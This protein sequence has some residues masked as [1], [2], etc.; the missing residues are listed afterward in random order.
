[1]R[2]MLVLTVCIGVVLAGLT[3]LA[4][5]KRVALV[6]GNDQYAGL[7]SL[8][9]AVNDARAVAAALEDIGFQ[10]FIGEDLTRRQ[11]NRKLADFE[12]AIA[13]G[14]QVFF[15][16]AGHGVS[17]GAENYL[18][19][20]DMPKPGTGEAGLVRDEA[21]AVSTLISRVQ[22]RG[23]ASTF[24]VLDACRDNPFAA[25]GVRSIG[26]SR[27][28]AKV[29]APNG[30]FVLFSAGIGQSALD[31]LSDN[32][33]DANSVFTRKLVPLLKR[34]GLTHVKLA[35]QVQRQV[36]TLAGTVQHNQQ[37]AYYDQ[38][39]GEIVLKPGTPQS[40]GQPTASDSDEAANTWNVIQNTSSPAVLKAFVDKY[41]DSVFAT[42]ARARLE[43]LAAK[44][45]APGDQPETAA[46]SQE[47][48]ASSP[49]EPQPDARSSDDTE[50][51]EAIQRELNRHGC[52]AGPV[53]GS[54]GGKSRRAVVSYSR[55]TKQSLDPA[56]SQQLL[57]VLRSRKTRG[58]PR[59]VVTAPAPQDDPPAAQQQRKWKVF[60]NPKLGGI[61]VDICLVKG[62]RC[63]GAAATVYCRSKGYRV[64]T[65]SQTLV[66]PATRHI[67]SGGVC[68]PAGFV[69]CGGYS[70]ITCAR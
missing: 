68:K 62:R 12:A 17:L 47:P 58:C 15:F 8:R 3:T 40:A 34:P 48:A 36:S 49:D 28:L 27:G 25:A 42:F 63:K 30:V 1:M 45:P 65:A 26:A 9:K 2:H 32:D 31:R 37:P 70:T 18:I 29:D 43:E 33:G 13:P 60:S 52:N 46:L 24:F 14:D 41:P 35:K 7:P 19:P 59:P 16:F 4:N 50:L 22:R 53:D 21:H 10:V 69:L 55:Y 20:S 23:A 5:A 67:G 61:P 44:S 11:T 6:I 51:V 57:D 66:Y 38:I 54:W 39:I 64:A 56:P